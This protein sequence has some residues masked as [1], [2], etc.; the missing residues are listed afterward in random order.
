VSVY[1]GVMVYGDSGVGKSSLI[2][3]GLL[4]I[5]DEHGFAPERVRVQP[6]PGEE[7]VVER[8]SLEEEGGPYLPS[9]FAPEGDTSPLHVVSCDDFAQKV[10]ETATAGRP[11]LVFDQFEEL[12]TLFE[13]TDAQRSQ[14]CIVEMLSGLL[15]EGVSAKL[16]F[17]FRDD[18]LARIKSLL[19]AAPELVDQ[20]LWLRPPSAGALPKI[21]RG[22]F[23][24]YP[25]H[26]DPELDPTLCD[27]LHGVLVDR[28][29]SGEVSL[30]EVQTVCL[31]LWRADDPAALLETRGVQGLLEDYLGEELDRFPEDLRYAAAA[32]LSQMVTSAGTRNVISADDLY[33]RVEEEEKIPRS[34][35]EQALE[36]LE[37]KSK[38]VRRER[39]RDQYLYEITSEFLVP[40]ISAR[41]Q[42]LV[43]NA[44]QRRVRRRLI[45]SGTVVLS[46]ALVAVFASVTLLVIGQR[47][48]A[49]KKK[50]EAEASAEVAGAA[51]RLGTDPAEALAAAV[52][53]AS[54]L[55][56]VSGRAHDQAMSLLLRAALASRLKAVLR[57]DGTPIIAAGYE[58]GGSRLVTVHAS[59]VAD[60]WDVKSMR[61]AATLRGGGP[62][63]SALFSDSGSILA[64]RSNQGWSLWDTTS[65]RRVAMLPGGPLALSPDGRMIAL[66]RSGRSPL[67][68][69]YSVGAR[70][71]RLGRVLTFAQ[72]PRKFALVAFVADAHRLLGVFE[73]GGWLI[74]DVHT[75]HRSVSI[76]ERAAKLLSRAPG[77]V[78]AATASRDG[79]LVAVAVNGGVLLPRGRVWVYK[80][81]GTKAG[82]QEHA[83]WLGVPLSSLTSAS[84]GRV[85]FGFEDGS[86]QI[87]KP[88]VSAAA[89]PLRGYTGPVTTIVVSRDGRWLAT[90]S[91]ADNTAK[92]WDAKTGDLRATLL[93]HTDG[94]RGLAF[95]PDGQ[96]IVTTSDDGTAR[97]W[98]TLSTG[99]DVALPRH[100]GRVGHAS[101]SGDGKFV[102]TAGVDGSTY[103]V[104][105]STGQLMN[106]FGPAQTRKRL[107][108]FIEKG[109]G[110]TANPVWLRFGPRTALSADGTRLI[111]GDATGPLTL[112]AAHSGDAVLPTRE[113]VFPEA[114]LLDLG[115]TNSWAAV[116]TMR[117][118]VWLFDQRTGRQL[119]RLASDRIFPFAAAASA[120]GRYLVTA[121]FE[122]GRSRLQVWDVPTRRLALTTPSLSRR[123][124]LVAIDRAGTY[125]AGGTSA[126]TVKIWRIGDRGPV[127]TLR[128]GDRLRTL[129]F[130][131]N[132]EVLATATDGRL[133]DLWN[134]P[135]GRRLHRLRGHAGGI[136]SVDFSPDDRLVAT[137]SDDGTVRVWKVR[138]G[139][140]LA[141]FRGAR[142]GRALDAS[143]SPDGRRIVVAASDGSSDI[144]ACPVCVGEEELFKFAEEQ[145]P[146]VP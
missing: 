30:S 74:W 128:A 109:L 85:V 22:P 10:R 101:F 41:R 8:I 130:S 116:P 92:I 93:G 32:L 94:I 50:G 65:R 97:L 121:E 77:T 136:N 7:I 46:I 67:V 29:G 53:A 102:I 39:R 143:F 135:G 15:R 127:V 9:A 100:Y 27:R 103:L 69:L 139:K 115:P 60:F 78:A 71:L 33:M 54:R 66:A 40:W 64:I 73:Q 58:A 59:G 83:P 1:R 141:V 81:R 86:A 31:R 106:T 124:Q 11:L 47:N 13:G 76:T 35:L 2:N 38:L 87:W 99:P 89:T 110:E 23:E 36:R 146:Q 132:G 122:H 107:R 17:V 12:V 131:P 112:W 104:R 140:V 26:F 96:E 119:G 120:D 57:G 79:S 19:A 16:L 90:A 142:P 34:R 70:G 25:G 75:G 144:Y 56:R 145:A 43:H 52:S 91:N 80:A 123:I 3:A 5:A 118:G 18:Y 117:S 82:Q 63:K 84:E 114:A 44:E 133:A 51:L 68:R 49:R 21:I 129:A 126:G 55:Q 42:E 98:R 105:A 62:A 14:D 28:F 134:V 125:V 37:S 45:I 48:E 24:E 72:G 138:D 113:H 61:H 95:S 108:R 111:T 4:P 88:R 20:A 137:A 6:R